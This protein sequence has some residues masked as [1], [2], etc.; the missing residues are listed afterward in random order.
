MPYTP[1]WG[2]V[3]RHPLDPCLSLGKETEAAGAGEKQR[4]PLGAASS[5]GT[6]GDTWAAQRAGL[7]LLAGWA[8]LSRRGPDSGGCVGRW[9]RGWGRPCGD[10]KRRPDSPLITSPWGHCDR[11]SQG[12][13]SDSQHCTQ[14]SSPG[15]EGWRWRA[16][17]RRISGGQ[18]PGQG[19]SSQSPPWQSPPLQ[20]PAP[21]FSGANRA[22]R[23]PGSRCRSPVPQP[24]GPA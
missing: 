20:R 3:A 14:G 21:S 24:R 13:G 22:R 23:R 4:G 10:V 7:G 16:Q 19:P 12:R 6:A 15:G 11:L 2:S 8:P 17:A 9:A 1:S 5:S 18:S